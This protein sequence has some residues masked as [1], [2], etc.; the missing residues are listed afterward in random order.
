MKKK[1]DYK[2]LFAS[3]FAILTFVMMIVILLYFI[4]GKVNLIYTII[5]FSIAGFSA[6]MF[7]VFTILYF[8]GPPSLKNKR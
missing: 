8:L 5:L 3:L 2:N 6:I 4:V 7:I 1:Q